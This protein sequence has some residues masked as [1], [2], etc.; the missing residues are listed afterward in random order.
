M[1]QGIH[2]NIIQYIGTTKHLIP[3]IHIGHV[4]GKEMCILCHDIK[5]LT[6]HNTDWPGLP[7]TFDRGVVP[8]GV[9]SGAD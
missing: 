2:G 8:C 1:I 4:L 3:T 5:Q 7:W 9:L 6:W